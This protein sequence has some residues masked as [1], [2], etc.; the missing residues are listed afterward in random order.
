MGLK[1]ANDIDTMCSMQIYMYQ[2]C[3]VLREDRQALRPYIAVGVIRSGDA[4][5]TALWI[6]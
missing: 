5:V 3:A 1:V 4:S 6:E 2:D